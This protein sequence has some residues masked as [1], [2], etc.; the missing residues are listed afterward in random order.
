MKKSIILLILTTLF[1]TNNNVF[2]SAPI[3]SL[4]EK[5]I[6]LDFKTS[7]EEALKNKKELSFLLIA[8]FTNEELQAWERQAT[9]DK[10]VKS[11]KIK[12]YNEYEGW[13]VVLSLKNEINRNNAK[14]LFSFSVKADYMIVG[15]EKMLT[16]I[17]V[18]KHIPN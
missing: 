10:N 3:N 2:S 16:N 12:K 5:E 6:I 17:F 7:M 18:S 8:N 1:I 15:N 9:S 4:L 14:I 13:D 11:I